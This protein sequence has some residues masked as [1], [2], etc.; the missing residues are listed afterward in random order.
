MSRALIMQWHSG[1]FWTPSEPFA[2]FGLLC[3][4]TDGEAQRKMCLGV[5]K[6]GDD[7]HLGGYDKQQPVIK[8][9]I[10][11]ENKGLAMHYRG[12]SLINIH[13]RFATMSACVWRS[14]KAWTWWWHL[15]VNRQSDK[16]L[17]CD[18][19]A[20]GGSTGLCPGSSCVITPPLLAFALIVK[21]TKL[22]SQ[23][24]FWNV[25]GG[26]ACLTIYFSPI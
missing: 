6:L 5:T 12:C 11:V 9:K 10:T 3:K 8:S 22:A 18:L 23:N 1:N 21:V 17:L 2:R 24:I 16:C 15:S 25:P 13:A 7:V 19:R 20:C 14:H 26:G 4:L